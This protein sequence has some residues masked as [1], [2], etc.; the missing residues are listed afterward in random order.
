MLQYGLRGGGAETRADK[1]S[2]RRQ[3]DEARGV[4]TKKKSRGKKSRE[5]ARADIREGRQE[6]ETR[7]REAA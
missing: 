2:R 3:V 1:R 5:E 6:Q 7:Q 4:E